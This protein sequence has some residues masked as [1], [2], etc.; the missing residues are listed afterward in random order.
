MGIIIVPKFDLEI[1]LN[2]KDYAPLSHWR[3]AINCNAQYIKCTNGELVALNATIYTLLDDKTCIPKRVF[4]S[5]AH[6]DGVHLD[7]LKSHLSSLERSGRIVPWY[8]GK[9]LAGQSWD[10]TLKKKLRESDIVL[11]LLSKN[12]MA[13]Q[14]IWETE[15]PIANKAGAVIIPIF[16]SPV[17]SEDNVINIHK[18]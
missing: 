4:L 16:L 13:S 8:D 7:D 5:Y 6:E 2:G 3:D 15:L 10:D 11:A 1:S 18:K 9:I 17:F 14:Y 12:F